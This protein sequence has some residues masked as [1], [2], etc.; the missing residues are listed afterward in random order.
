[1]L[2]S[3]FDTQNLLCMGD[4]LYF[5]D[6]HITSS[7]ILMWHFNT[8]ILLFSFVPVEL[9]QPPSVENLQSQIKKQTFGSSTEMTAVSVSDLFCWKFNYVIGWFVYS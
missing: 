2:G 7:L 1:M 4:N 3:T 6:L 8:L 9:F 5:K